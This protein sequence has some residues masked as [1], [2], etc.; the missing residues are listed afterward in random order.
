[1]PAVVF[2]LFLTMPILA[3]FFLDTDLFV[4]FLI[5]FCVVGW[6]STSSAD[7]LV[8]SR[9]KVEREA[10][11]THPLQPHTQNALA[12]AY[13]AS[14]RG[15]KQPRVHSLNHFQ[16]VTDLCERAMNRLS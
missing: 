7:P 15:E 5:L 6:L 4:L 14:N 1:V 10:V 8:G 13:R 2:L 11:L 9:R 12:P 3:A 16:T